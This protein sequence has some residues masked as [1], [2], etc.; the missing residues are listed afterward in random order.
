MQPENAFSVSSPSVRCNNLHFNFLLFYTPWV[1]H[2]TVPPDLHLGI[3]QVFFHKRR[4]LN[5]QHFLSCLWAYYIEVWSIFYPARLHCI[6]ARCKESQL[7]EIQFQSNFL[8]SYD[9]CSA[10]RCKMN[11]CVVMDGIR[12]Q[13]F[14]FHRQFLCHYFFVPWIH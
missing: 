9:C 11:L 14:V 5:S 3:T 13:Q 6:T 12:C 2:C 7:I 8:F 4:S 1:W 10:G